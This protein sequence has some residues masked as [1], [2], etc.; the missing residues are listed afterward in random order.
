[1]WKNLLLKTV[2]MTLIWFGQLKMN[3]EQLLKSQNGIMNVKNTVIWNNEKS[4][5]GGAIKNG[6]FQQNVISQTHRIDIWNVWWYDG[7][8]G[9][10]QTLTQKKGGICIEE[11]A[12][13]YGWTVRNGGNYSRMI[14]LIAT[15]AVIT[16]CSIKKRKW[17]NPLPQKDLRLAG[18]LFSC[19]SCMG[20][21]YSLSRQSRNFLEFIEE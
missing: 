18:P 7:N 2:S 20:K 11:I 15:L 10:H 13:C 6:W 12:E 5:G 9:F 19:Q 3:S 1:M 17:P 8:M 4:Q 16:V 21:S 14:Y